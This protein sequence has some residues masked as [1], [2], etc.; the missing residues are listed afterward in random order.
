LAANQIANN[1]TTISF[2]MIVGVSSATT[3]RVSHQLGLRDFFA[4]KMA[5]RAS[6]HL[7]LFLNAIMACLMIGFRYQIP[8]IFTTD[9]DVVE[10]TA[11]LLVF[12]GLFQLSDGLQSVGAGVLRGLTDVKRLVFYAFVTYICVNIPLGYVLAFTFN[13]GV[14][15]IWV[16]FIISLTLAAVL[17]HRRCSV[18]IKQLEQQLG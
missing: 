13:I 12:A 2:M 3:I 14:S 16:A 18:K 1:V 4:L 10:I 7:C 5:M 17:Y 8:L 9:R 15:G 11:Q 6:I